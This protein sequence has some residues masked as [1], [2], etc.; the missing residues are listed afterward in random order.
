MRSGLY[1]CISKC[2]AVAA[3]IGLCFTPIPLLG[4]TPATSSDQQQPAP[5]PPPTPV[6]QA[7]TPATQTP[8]AWRN[9]MATKPAPE[10]GGCY[11]SSYPA[12]DWQEVPCATNVPQRPHPP[13]TTPGD[14]LVNVP[15]P[16]VSVQGT[17]FSATGV[18]SEC[19]QNF[20]AKTA[21][22]ATQ[23]PTSPNTFSL[24]LNTNTFS[25]S[26]CPAGSTCLGW[27]QYIYDNYGNSTPT[28]P[29]SS[30]YIQYWLVYFPNPHNL[31][32]PFRDTRAWCD[33]KHLQ[34]T[35]TGCPG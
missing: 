14:R 8:D 30:I 25:S 16:I 28:D 20:G 32:N 21:C 34:Y 13:Q 6:P 17:F 7:T 29:K 1:H 2:A 18:T 35:A 31:Q 10:S 24:Q 12:T 3:T 19:D 4:A 23:P 26:L 15:L 27:Q 22:D 5:A 11:T 33:R 9:L